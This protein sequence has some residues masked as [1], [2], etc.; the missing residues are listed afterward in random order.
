[1]ITHLVNRST[2]ERLTVVLEIGPTWWLKDHSGHV[3]K[4]ERAKFSPANWQLFGSDLPL[5]AHGFGQAF[6]PS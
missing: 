2:E 6:N 4:A 3:L 5:D 1:M